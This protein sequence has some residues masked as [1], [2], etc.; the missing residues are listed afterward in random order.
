MADSNKFMCEDGEFILSLAVY[1]SNM[2]I[3][4]LGPALFSREG[5]WTSGNHCKDL[6]WSINKVQGFAA[7]RYGE[8]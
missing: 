2:S 8:V 4:D 1:T 5:D 7:Y 6:A 3:D